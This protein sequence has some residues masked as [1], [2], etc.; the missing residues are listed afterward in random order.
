MATLADVMTSMADQIRDVLDD[1]TDIDIQ[2]EGRMIINATPP[3]VDIFPSDPSDDLSL[4][5]MGDL[6]G[7]ELL[8]IRAR[9]ST[10]DQ[11]AGQDLLLAFM[12]DEDPLSIAAALH[13]DL[14]VGRRVQTLDLLSRSGYVLVPDA[15]G[16]GAYLGC[17]WTVLVVKA[18][19]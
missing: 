18:Q 5:A 14:T 6:D 15:G 1:T 7:A 11:D 8:T 19:S 12:D 2:V 13:D 4:A 10:S 9:V 17:L 3:T 16:D